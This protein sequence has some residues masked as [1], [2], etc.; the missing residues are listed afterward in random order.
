MTRLK[1]EEQIERI[2]KDIKDMT[3]FVSKQLRDS[4]EALSNLDKKLSKEIV[5]NDR[6]AN[7]L[8]TNIKGRCI[9]TI[10]L[11]QPVARDLRFISISMDVASNLERVGDYA[12]D[13]AKNVEYISKEPPRVRSRFTTEI[14]TLFEPDNEI[15]FIFE[16]GRIAEK[17]VNK[18]GRVFISNDEEIIKE[19]YELEDKLDS[20]FGQIFQKL[21]DATRNDTKKIHFALNLILIARHLERIG[22]HAVNIANRTLYAIRGNGEY[23]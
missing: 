5:G 1:L 13:I 4:M 6:I 9:Q 11:Q 12:V 3:E 17:M 19:I 8:Y 7:E 16:M 23:I 21:E 2:K 15:A 14:L 18:S 22:D 10:A 20:L